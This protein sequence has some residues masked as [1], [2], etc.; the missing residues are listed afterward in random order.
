M[1]PDV[2]IVGA[3]KCGTSAMAHYLAGHPEI[4]MARKEM[5]FFG[6]DLR[7]GTQFYRRDQAAYLEEY[8][9]W[10][11]QTHAAEASVWYLFSKR[12]AEEIHAF[13]PEARIIILLREPAEMLYSLYYQFR[14]DGN[15]YLPSFEEA[16]RAEGE[17][18]A[19][20][21]VGRRT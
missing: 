3:P 2:F 12:A 10:N 18:V 9:S 8:K 21:S 7:F 16:L 19:G 5:H 14:F 13:N 4:F 11:G 20:R 17:R 6:S 15:E 1:R